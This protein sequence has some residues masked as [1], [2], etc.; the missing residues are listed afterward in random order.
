MI[1]LPQ[2]ALPD[3]ASTYLQQW[4]GEVDGAPDY[5]RR[6]AAAKKRFPQKNKKSNATFKAVKQALTQMCRGARRCVYCEDSVADEVEH[7]APKDLYPERV[8]RWD[9]YVYACGQCN[10]PKNARYGVLTA[11][12]ELIEVT[13]PDDA[14]VAEPL[15]GAPALINPREEDPLPLLLLD[16]QTLGFTAVATLQG[17]EK[18]RADFTIDVLRLGP[19]SRE[20]LQDA[21]LEALA[22][23]AAHLARYIQRRDEGAP[24]EELAER[25][26]KIVIHRH[27]TVWEE[28]KRQRSVIPEV[29]DLF[30]RAPEAL[31][32]S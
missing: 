18:L 20:Y 12:G 1:R 3:S 7:I 8:F 19:G 22:D 11:A 5:S 15:A 26:R 13:R 6:V 27:P 28:M 14:E 25:R 32:W 30:T 17:V 24:A 23:F 2:T 9:N 4:Q 29:D 16:V 31:D 10:G 21:W